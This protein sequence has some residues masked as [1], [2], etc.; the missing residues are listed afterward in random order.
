MAGTTKEQVLAGR[1]AIDAYRTAH[2]QLY[3]SMVI[4]AKDIPDTHTPLLEKALIDLKKQGFNSLDEFF[5]ANEEF[6][7]LELGL[8]GKVLTKED[9]ILL[10]EK[11]H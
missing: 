1:A 7:L 11:W 10:V 4:S 6:N 3:K 9:K 2:A 8:T 5:K